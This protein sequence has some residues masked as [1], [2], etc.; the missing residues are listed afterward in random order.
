MCSRKRGKPAPKIFIII[1]VVGSGNDL[2]RKSL[3]NAKTCF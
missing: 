3:K 2:E 1:T